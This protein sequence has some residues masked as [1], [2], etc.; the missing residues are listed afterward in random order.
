VEKSRRGRNDP[1]A[2]HFSLD[3]PAIFQW[4]SRLLPQKEM[5]RFIHHVI[6]IQ[7]GT[8]VYRKSVICYQL[9]DWINFLADVSSYY[10]NGLVNIRVKGL[11]IRWLKHL[12][13]ASANFGFN[14]ILE[15]NREPSFSSCKQPLSLK[16]KLSTTAPLSPNSKLVTEKPLSNLS[17][18]KIS[19]IWKAKFFHWDPMIYS[20]HV[21]PSSWW[22][23]GTICS[24]ISRSVEKHSR[25]W[26][27]EMTVQKREVQKSVSDVTSTWTQL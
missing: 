27:A 2:R 17:H 11:T 24:N 18:A 16:S 25:N 20:Y 21:F 9:W 13:E 22:H 14:L 19:W 7:V 4:M 1:A 23:C 8:Y 5:T 15:A 10:L 26:I 12:V 3:D 6:I